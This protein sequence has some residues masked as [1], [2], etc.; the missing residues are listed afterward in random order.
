MRRAA[1]SGP[2]HSLAVSSSSS[3][4]PARCTAPRRRAAGWA[5][6]CALRRRRRRLG[7][8]RLGCRQLAPPL[9]V[10][11]AAVAKAHHLQGVQDGTCLS[12]CLGAASG[13]G[14]SRGSGSLPGS[15]LLLQ[16]ST[17][18]HSA[19]APAAATPTHAAPPLHP[20]RQRRPRRRPCHHTTTRRAQHSPTRKAKLA[21]SSGPRP[22]AAIS[23]GVTCPSQRS[24]RQGHSGD[25]EH[26][27]ASARPASGSVPCAGGGAGGGGRRSAAARAL[28]QAR[29]T[30]GRRGRRAAGRRR[31]RVRRSRPLL[32][33]PPTSAL[34]IKSRSGC[35]LCWPPG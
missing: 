24:Q 31:Q 27:S 1:S 33:A 30:A 13:P 9:H 21:Y 4:R 5:C 11:Q 26:A 22:C 15:L 32:P 6:P 7:C 8:C 34:E 12:R 14:S 20:T 17:L 35:R 16:Q 29:G 2:I 10:R 18:M 23:A 3:L 28:L 25:C 19:A